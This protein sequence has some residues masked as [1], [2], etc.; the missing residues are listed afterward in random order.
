MLRP[1][2]Y[3]E[4]RAQLLDRTTTFDKLG[5]IPTPRQ[6]LLH[7]AT[8]WDVLYGGAAGGGKSKALVAEAL[9]VAVAY[10]G[11]R[12]AAFRRTYDELAESLLKELAGFDFAHALGGQWNGSR[13]ELTFPNRSLIRFRFAERVEDATRRQGG[14]YQLILVDERGLMPPEVVDHLM[15]R[16]RSGTR[17][18]PV[19][20]VRSSTNPGGIGHGRLKARFID[21][22]GNGQHLGHDEQGHTLRFIPA[23]VDDNPYVDAG[24]RATLMA[25]PDP[26][27]RR[28]M[29][30]GDWDTFAGQFFSEW[31]RTRH[32]VRPF[33]V[34]AE[35]QRF[36]GVDYGYAAPW[37]VV[38][39][40][41][42]PDDRAWLY[43]E[44]YAT[45]VGEADQA[46]QILT[47]EDGERIRKRV[48]DPAMWAKTGT[49]PSVATAYANEGVRLEPAQNDRVIGWQRVHTY[50][51]DMPACPIHRAQ[52]LEY[53]PRLHVFESCIN[54]TRTLPALPFDQRRA[55]D[56]DTHAEDHLADAA[57]YV[58]M[59]ISTPRRTVIGSARRQSIPTGLD[60]TIGARR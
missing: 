43:R 18:I 60:A 14:E 29:M 40:A 59:A 13:H 17:A 46:R 23:K 4:A 41:V 32:V 33:P 11:I 10:P 24:Y 28:A 44:L 49:A 15:E 3:R 5:Y 51:G 34:P 19:L 2:S 55:E 45:K 30:D 56:L 27:R 31:S 38:W 48:G 35:W 54:T 26:A 47:V 20:G 50:L 36:I 53:C 8:E 1:G 57:R 7:E 12:V 39:I 6:R 58:L 22:T 37:A 42:D 9:R 25:I 21:G 52:G 16:L